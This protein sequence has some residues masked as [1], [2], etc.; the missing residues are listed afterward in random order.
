[1]TDRKRVIILLSIVTVLWALLTFSVVLWLASLKTALILS[2][3]GTAVMFPIWIAELALLNHFHRRAFKGKSKDDNTSP[4]Q[5]KVVEVDL[6]FHETF[7]LCQDAIKTI[8]G[9]KLRAMGFT[10]TIKARVKTADPDTGT[11]IGKTR[12]WWWKIPDIYEEMRLTLKLEQVTPEVTRVHINN[13]PVLPSVVFDWGYGLNN[14]NVVALYLREQAHLRQAETH[15]LDSTADD[16][17]VEIDQLERQEHM[18]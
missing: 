18:L 11:I 16:I 4:R 13:R 8:T 14:V 5:S 15:L 12:T 17:V 9:A 10:H 7:D 3:I 1:M 2:L 6:P